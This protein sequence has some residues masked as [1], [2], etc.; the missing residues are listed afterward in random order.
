MILSEWPASRSIDKQAGKMLRVTEHEAL[1][2]IAS[3]SAQLTNE[4]PNTDRAEF[5]CDVRGGKRIYFS[6]AVLSKKAKIS[7]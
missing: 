3:L 4:N 6:V 1:Q 2:I 7:P 5:Q